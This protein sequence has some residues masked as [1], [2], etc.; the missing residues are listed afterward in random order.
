MNLDEVLGTDKK[1]KD[2]KITDPK[3]LK[4]LK[5]GDRHLAGT[6]DLTKLKDEVHVPDRSISLVFDGREEKPAPEVAERYK[7]N[8][9]GKEFTH[10]HQKIVA[11]LM[12][13]CPKCD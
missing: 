2:N 6:P 13:Q 11:G 7:C 1:K 3:L 10:T 5:K 9:C 12:P 8:K 4:Y